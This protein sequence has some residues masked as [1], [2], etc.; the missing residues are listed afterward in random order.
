MISQRPPAPTFEVLTSPCRAKPII[1]LNRAKMEITIPPAFPVFYVAS[2]QIGLC[3][4]VFLTHGEAQDLVNTLHRVW[5]P[6]TSKAWAKWFTMQ[7]RSGRQIAG[8]AQD[9]YGKREKGN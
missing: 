3:G 1:L 6:S 5:R 9:T 8:I 7:Y 4:A 2:R